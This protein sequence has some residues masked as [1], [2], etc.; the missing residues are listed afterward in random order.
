[1]IDIEIIPIS[2]KP[3]GA[4]VKNFD[5]AQLGDFAS[6][7]LRAHLYQYQVLVFEKQAHLTPDQEVAFYQAL[8][9]DNGSIWR[10]QVNNP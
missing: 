10:D 3:F 1:M 4:V 7:Q 6:A 8:N 2:E 9:P 5:C